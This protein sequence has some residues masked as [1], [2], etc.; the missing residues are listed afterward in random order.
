MN[1]EDPYRIAHQTVGGRGGQPPDARA[2][3]QRQTG[4]ETDP[5]QRPGKLQETGRVGKAVHGLN[6]ELGLFPLDEKTGRTALPV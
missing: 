4:P 5:G 3:N 6:G 1:I 2:Q